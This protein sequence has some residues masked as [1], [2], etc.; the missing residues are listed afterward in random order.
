ML[1]QTLSVNNY[2]QASEKIYASY[3]ALERSISVTALEDYAKKGVIDEDLAVY[4]HYLKH[5]QLQQLRRALLSPIKI[6]SVAV[7]QFLYTP[8][9]E[10]LLRRLAEVIKT[11]SRQPQA[12][13]F[14]LRSALILASAEPSG[15]TLLNVLRNYPSPSIRIDLERTMGMVAELE[16]LVNETNWAIATVSQRSNIEAATTQARLNF[17]QLPDLGLDTPTPRRSGIYK[18]FA[19]YIPCG[20]P[21]TRKFG[22]TDPLMQNRVENP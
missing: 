16:H 4:Q 22:S 17:S 7:S 5:V 9:G 12:G 18:D 11:E 6:N 20:F 8:Q 10:F 15:L 21:G 19:L 3:S 1:L 2:T 14:A 13:L